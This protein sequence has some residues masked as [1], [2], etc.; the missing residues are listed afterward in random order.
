MMND[1]KGARSQKKDYWKLSQIRFSSIHH[2]SFIIQ[3]KGSIE[4]A[5]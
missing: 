5:G 3:N 1:E 2:S 4:R